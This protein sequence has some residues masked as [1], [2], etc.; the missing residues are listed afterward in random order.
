MSSILIQVI[1]HVIS[2]SYLDACSDAIRLLYEELMLPLPVQLSS[3][4]LDTS[5]AT[6][7]GE[8]PFCSASKPLVTVSA[9]EDNARFQVT[10]MDS[11][12]CYQ[13]DHNSR[14]LKR[15]KS[16]HGFPVAKKQITVR[17]EKKTKKTPKVWNSYLNWCT[18]GMSSFRVTGMNPNPGVS[19]TFVC[20]FVS[21]FSCVCLS[22]C[23]CVCEHVGCTSS[24]Y[25][26]HTIIYMRTFVY[27]MQL[28]LL[29]N[30]LP[31]ELVNYFMRV[32][33]HYLMNTSNTHHTSN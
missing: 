12:N 1:L 17:V 4:T 3:P 25:D 7:D 10:C 31:Q 5:C 27:T 26:L 6:S 8:S 16:F 20:L 18:Y 24:M 33:T 9:V 21:V 13:L 22:V 28:L 23:A 2:I 29:H 14:K 15:F 19:L 11:L 32:V 30:S